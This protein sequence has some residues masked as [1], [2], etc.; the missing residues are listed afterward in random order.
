[1]PYDP[2]LSDWK[3]N[4]DKNQQTIIHDTY[5][6]YWFFCYW[7]SRRI[8]TLVFLF[9]R[10]VSNFSSLLFPFFCP[11]LN[12]KR[13]KWFLFFDQTVVQYSLCQSNFLKCWPH[14]LTWSR[15]LLS[16]KSF[17]SPPHL[18]GWYY[19]LDWLIDLV[20]FFYCPWCSGTHSR[21]YTN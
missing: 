14:I 9:Q 15:Y 19:H 10:L 6:W 11:I 17:D 2:I 12:W 13:I 18:S 7:F 21:T 5:P 20:F 8:P 1:M 4:K 16:E 3:K